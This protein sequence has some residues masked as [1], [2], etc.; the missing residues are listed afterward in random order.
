[1]LNVAR[2][3]VEV[4]IDFAAANL[5]WFTAWLNVWLLADWKIPFPDTL[6][7]ACGP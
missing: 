6:I 4:R 2:I 1:V 5:N 7:F 3:M